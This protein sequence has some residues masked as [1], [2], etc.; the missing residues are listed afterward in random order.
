MN[1]CLAQQVQVGMCSL[2]I[3]SV[4]NGKMFPQAENKDCSDCADAQT[5]LKLRSTHIPAGTLCS[6]AFEFQTSI[7]M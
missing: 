7:N 3:N 2:Q 6:L 5:G 4:V 1:R